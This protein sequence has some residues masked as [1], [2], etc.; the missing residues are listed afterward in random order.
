M[1]LERPL[2]NWLQWV[3]EEL[4]LVGEVLGPRKSRKTKWMTRRM[5]KRRIHESLDESLIAHQR[6]LKVFKPCIDRW[7]DPNNRITR[8][9]AA[10]RNLT[11]Q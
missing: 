6:S 1:G 7:N 2:R 5:R 4:E 9:D 3:E 8:V 10:S 11:G